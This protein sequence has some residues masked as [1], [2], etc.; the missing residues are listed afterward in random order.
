MHSLQEVR[1]TEGHSLLAH[2]F[3]SFYF[4]ISLITASNDHPCCAV[5]RRSASPTGAGSTLVD[6]REIAYTYATH[7]RNTA[8]ELISTP[9][10]TRT[11]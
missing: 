1:G 8:L 4:F 10:N 7:M 2:I 6:L 11:Q 9:T 5:G 3:I